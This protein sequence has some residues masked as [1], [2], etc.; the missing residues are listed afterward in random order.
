[1]PPERK[2]AMMCLD[3]FVTSDKRR[4]L[5]ERFYLSDPASHER[6]VLRYAIRLFNILDEKFGLGMKKKNLL[7]YAA[8]LHDI[9][10]E[11]SPQKHD[12]HTREMLLEDPCFDFWPQPG[13]T[14][15]ALIAG[16]HRKKIGKELLQLSPKNQRT[17]RQLTSILR[18][19]DAI[20]YP[21]D[22]ALKIVDARLTETRLELVIHSDA[23]ASVAARVMQ[24]SQLFQE[25]FGL[26]VLI[27]EPNEGI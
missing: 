23:C 7:A 12:T 16:G 3:P 17:V 24:K 14:M 10:Y 1:M 11:V 27:T 9:G 6:R 8:L 26:S 5:E 20:D 22:E 15:L 25:I 4:E 21:R 13:R 18:I 19:A 2:N